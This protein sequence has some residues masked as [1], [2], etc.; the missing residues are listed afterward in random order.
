MEEAIEFLKEFPREKDLP[1]KELFTKALE[2]TSV[3]PQRMQDLEAIYRTS[4][5]KKRVLFVKDNDL[6]VTYLKALPNLPDDEVMTECN[7]EEDSDEE[8]Y[9]EEYS[10]SVNAVKKRQ[11][12]NSFYLNNVSSLDQRPQ[13]GIDSEKAIMQN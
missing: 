1:I 7:V 3:T 6:D 4:K 10:P 9:E 2:F 5:N 11:I 12:N 8:R 13:S